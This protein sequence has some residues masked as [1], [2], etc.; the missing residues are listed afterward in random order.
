MVKKLQLNHS[1]ISISVC[2]QSVANKKAR[3][4]QKPNSLKK[5]SSLKIIFLLGTRH[6]RQFSITHNILISKNCV[7]QFPKKCID[8]KW[9]LNHLLLRSYMKRQVNNYS[10]P[11]MMCFHQS[12]N[13]INKLHERAFRHKFHDYSSSFNKFL[14]K[15]NVTALHMNTL[16][17]FILEVV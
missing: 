5:L 13:V 12:N 11:R 4:Y 7:Q 8:Q 9:T 15:T 1:Q 2:L 14:V 16:R 6:F 10:L 17:K 3:T